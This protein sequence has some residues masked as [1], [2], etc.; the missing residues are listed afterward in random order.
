MLF[1]TLCLLSLQMQAVKVGV[2]LPL[3]DKTPVGE[4]L[5][6]FYR[7]FL[8][9]VD[10]VKHE[11][12]SVEVY[13]IDCGTTPQQLNEVLS[14]GALDDASLIFGPASPAQVDALATFCQRHAIRLVMP[15]SMPCAQIGTN[16]Y[17]VQTS[18]PQEALYPEVFQLVMENHANAR[19]VM[20]RSDE[21]NQRG[22]AFQAYLQKQLSGY[23]LPCQPLNVNADAATLEIAFSVS[24]PNVVVLD[25]PTESAFKQ[26][27]SLL[28]SYRSSHPHS[29]I[30][31]IGYPD[32]FAFPASSVAQFYDLDTY[33]CTPFYSNPLS[34]RTVRF[35]QKFHRCF[36]VDPS[37]S[38][39]SAAMQG[40]DLAYHFLCGVNPNPLQQDFHFRK[41][42][43]AGGL[44]NYFVQ[45]VHYTPNHHIQLL[46]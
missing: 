39:P 30:S 5:I 43:E 2:L 22:Q 1:F 28:A 31:V 6:E 4:T 38:M 12:L 23:G 18:L 44:Q 27:S 10:S 33:I 26:A 13:A 41:V 21:H 9:A 20:L 16:P 46:R 3:K 17:V 7:G 32:W 29:L 36:G 11:G 45:M 25:S 19:F 15:F 40:F 14:R 42:S 37:P 8:L 35:C 24:Q 34:G